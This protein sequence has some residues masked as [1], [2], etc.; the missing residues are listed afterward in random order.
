MIDWI[1][2]LGLFAP[3]LYQL[4]TKTELPKSM[5]LTWDNRSFPNVENSMD[6]AGVCQRCRDMVEDSN[7]PRDEQVEGS[8]RPRDEGSREIPLEY[9]SAWWLWEQKGVQNFGTI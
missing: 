3:K 2:L 7:R 4:Y 9:T 5:L 8:N 6:M 1:T